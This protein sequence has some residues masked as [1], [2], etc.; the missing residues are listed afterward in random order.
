MNVSDDSAV[1]D[2][3]DITVAPAP[4]SWEHRFAVCAASQVGWMGG[5]STYSVTLAIG[6]RLWLFS[7]TR[8]AGDWW[9][10]NSIVIQ[11]L[12]DTMR[13]MH[14]GTVADPDA[15]VMPPIRIGEDGLTRWLWTSDAIAF[16]DR[17]VPVA[18]HRLWTFSKNSV[19]PSQMRRR[20]SG[21]SCG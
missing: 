11:E 8:L 15:L 14:G 17:N 3:V 6:Q 12:D 7:D 19:Q 13:T 4:H 5:D 20:V 16:D 18:D 9:I 10:N 1:G 2:L 21:I